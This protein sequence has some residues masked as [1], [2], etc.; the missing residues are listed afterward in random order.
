[1]TGQRNL[2]GYFYSITGI[3]AI[4][5]T[6]AEKLSEIDTAYREYYQE[7]LRSYLKMLEKLY[8]TSKSLIYGGRKNV[9]LFSPILQYVVKD[10]GLNVEY[11]VVAEHGAEPSENDL[12]TLLDMLQTGKI[13]VFILT[14][15]EASHNEDLL[16]ILDEKNS[17]YIVIPL[18]ILSRNPET[19]QFSVT[20]SINLLHYQSTKNIEAGSQ[21]ILLIASI[22]VNIILLSLIIMFL[23]KVRRVGG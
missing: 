10:L 5:K 19:I 16:K 1:R 11:V 17:P 8:D 15:E 23:V 3:K 4:S 6:I 7:E 14:D 18:S 2:H 13:D 20:N 9:A 21:T 12:R 22:I